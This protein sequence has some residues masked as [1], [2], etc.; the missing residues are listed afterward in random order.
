M[1]EYELLRNEMMDNFKIISQNTSILYTSFAAIF[2]LAIK[3]NN[4]L[5]YLVPY[6]V[7][8]PLFLASEA[9]ARSNCR[10]AAYLSVYCEGSEYNWERRHQRLDEET[11]QKRNWKSTLS[12]YLLGVISSVAGEIQL[13]CSN[14][15]S[16]TEK[17]IYGS[18]IFL[19]TI[20]AF[21]I[22]K[23]NTIDYAKE[24]RKMINKWNKIKQQ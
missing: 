16:C 23:L 19:V 14:K 1:N 7:I 12:Y 10:I 3:E 20:I 5:L 6:F 9:K 11:H 4:F 17:W 2:A 15:Y 18:V 8:I 13:F 21:V 22:L 24:R